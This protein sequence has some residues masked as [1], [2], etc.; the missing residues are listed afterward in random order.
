MSIFAQ[1]FA[2][3]T[4]LLAMAVCAVV[5][6]VRKWED[7]R[8]SSTVPSS[9]RPLAPRAICECKCRQDAWGR[10]RTPVLEP[11][12]LMLEA[13]MAECWA[14]Y[15][16]GYF[17]GVGAFVRFS[18]VAYAPLVST[19][20]VALPCMVHFMVVG[21]SAILLVLMLLIAVHVSLLIAVHVS[22]HVSLFGSGSPSSCSVRV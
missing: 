16:G 10:G 17:L 1:T 2:C 13:T 11:H 20:H 14:W 18:S 8:S 5:E 9:L 6:V 15:R 22:L 4:S 19:W 21:P 12:W 3:F 7:P